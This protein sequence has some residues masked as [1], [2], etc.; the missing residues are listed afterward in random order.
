MTETAQNTDTGPRSGIPQM[1]PK[2]GHYMSTPRPGLA[3]HWIDKV[4][5]S[6]CPKCAEE[7]QADKEQYENAVKEGRLVENLRAAGILER[8]KEATL[9]TFETYTPALTIILNEIKDYCFYFEN[10][11]KFGRCMA[12]LGSPGL[13]KTH[14]GVAILRDIIG[15]GF[16]GLYTREYDFLREMKSAWSNN[17]SRRTAQEKEVLRHYIEPDL[18]VLDECGVHFFTA[19]EEVLLF[20][21]IEN[22]YGACK[23]SIIISNL[24]KP[25]PDKISST[26]NKRAPGTQAQDIEDAIGFRSFDRLMER[27]GLALEFRGNSYRRRLE[28]D[29]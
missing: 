2:H 25:A 8:F 16:T 11:L 19:A 23:P 13:G 9:E 26:D 7:A 18:L 6:G 20:Q 4:P 14:L 1:C 29:A 21:L 27:G 5:W 24:G 12:L 3:E 10:R 15:Q 17:N 28:V 22:R